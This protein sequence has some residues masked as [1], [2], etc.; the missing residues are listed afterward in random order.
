LFAVTNVNAT[1]GILDDWQVFYQDT[2]TTSDGAGCQLCHG[3]NTGTLN[4][5]GK[6]LCLNSFNFGA[7]ENDDSDMDPTGSNNLAE[8]EASAQPGWTDGLNPV[9]DTNNCGQPSNPVADVSVPSGVP[10]PYD[11]VAG[12]DPIADA[13]GPYETTLG[14]SIT[15]DGTGSSDDG[16]ITEYFW[17]FGDGSTNTGSIV[18][19]TY[20][21]VGVYDVTLTVTDND[22][23]SA[24]DT[25]TAT[26]LEPAALDLD[27][28]SFRVSKNI[29]LGKSI[30][31]VLTVTN[32]STVDAMGSATVVG[33]QN[34][35]VVFE[36][37]EPVFDEPGNGRTTFEFGPYTPDATGEIT[38]TVIVDDGNPDTDEATATSNVR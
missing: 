21:A 3:S 11:P 38:W 7:I 5:Y 26:V 9:Y 13:A 22:G 1:N 10:Q 34:G 20:D 36:Q 27:I 30:K 17:D 29:R 12:S 15:F 19:Y 18:T 16:S 35:S 14:N 25:T 31:I 8:I 32:E 6:D 2:P 28:A 37:T 23:N 33:E 24:S 4:P